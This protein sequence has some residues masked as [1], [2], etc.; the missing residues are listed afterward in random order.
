[1]VLR[2]VSALVLL[3]VLLGLVYW[4]IWAT[5]ALVAASVFAGLRELYAGFAHAGHHPRRRFGIGLALGFCLAAVLQGR[6]PF[7]LP[8]MVFALGLLCSLTYELLPRHR[9]AVLTNWALTFAG[10]CYIG[11]LLSYY[12][13]LRDLSAPLQ[14]A[15]LAFLQVPA[16]AAWVYMV[17]A[18][19][20]IQDSAAYFTGRSLGRHKMAP[21]ISPNK[22]WEGAAGGLLGATAAAALSA[23]LLGLPIALPAALLLGA[24]GGVIGPFGDLVESLIKRQVGV[25]DAGNLIPGHGGILDR[26]DSMLFTA[27]ALYYLILLLTV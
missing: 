11:G 6:L 27:P 14:A 3:P 12:I 26:M 18:I 16:G 20:W 24:V 23:W 22:T 17:L 25:K 9:E 21:Y 7:D 1:L 15:P 5:A 4:S 8:A 19:T 2:V 13:Q 10:A